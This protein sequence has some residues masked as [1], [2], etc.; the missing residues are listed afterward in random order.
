MTPGERDILFLSHRPPWPPTRGDAVR[1]W[2]V[3]NH[4]SERRRV[5][6]LTFGDPEDAALD[7]ALSRVVTSHRVIERPALPVRALVGAALAGAPASVALFQSDA[8][9]RAVADRLG[10]HPA[11][12]YA[13]SGQMAQYAPAGSILDFVDV[14][15]AKFGQYA[16]AARDPLRRWF[17]SRESR[18]LSQWERQM[19]DRA[20]SVLFVSEPEAA[21]WQARGGGPATVVP[22]GIDTAHFDPAL[23]GASVDGDGRP[24]ILFTGQMDYWPNV[25]A[26]IR[27]AREVLPKLAAR[28]VRFVV[29]GRSPTPAVRQLAGPDTLVTGEVDDMR[30]WLA[31][32]DVVVAPLTTARGVQNKVLEA[33]AMARPTVVSTAALTGLAL[34][35]GRDLLLADDPAEQAMAVTDLLDHPSRAADLGRAGRRTVVREYGWA[36]ALRPLDALLGTTTT[37]PA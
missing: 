37:Q 6:L 26:V 29:A 11:I 22:N 5:H 9:R 10:R 32:A 36:E 23:F 27:F 31:H 7:V 17:W 20:A 13:F 2:A 24:T 16:A 34:T 33:L 18:A 35:P 4:L 12:T 25:E 15:S 28:S 19:A 21:L 14:D 3:L 1:S 8:M 30:P